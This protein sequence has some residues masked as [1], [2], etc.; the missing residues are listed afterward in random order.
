MVNRIIIF[1]LEKRFC[2]GLFISALDQRQKELAPANRNSSYDFEAVS[3]TASGP[4]L[5]KLPFI[6]FIC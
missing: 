5:R 2:H 3:F 6:A 1:S 4:T